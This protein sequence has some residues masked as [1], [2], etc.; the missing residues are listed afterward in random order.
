LLGEYSGL[1]KEVNYLVFASIFPSLVIGMFY[2]DISYFLSQVQGLSAT[3]TGLVIAVMGISMVLASIPM[4]IA[5]D[6]YGRKKFLI[7]GNILASLIIAVFVLTTNPLLLILAAVVEG[8]SEAAFNASSSALIAEKAGNEKRTVA[9]ALFGF[10]SGI[11]MGVGSFMVP[12]VIIFEIFG[13]TSQEGHALLYI[14]LALISLASTAIMLKITE[15]KSL[16]KTE[17]GLRHLLPNKS[18][19]VLIK[20]VFANAIIAFGAGLV[21]PLM[22]MWFGLRYG[23]TDAISVPII[24]ISN[25]V[26]GIATLAAPPL[27]R[28]IGL[29]RAIVVTQ[30]VSTIFMFATPI[31]PE[32][33]SASFVYTIRSFLMN[34]ASPLQN[35]MIM[36][37]VAEDERGTASG[38]SGALWRL[39]NAVSAIVGAWL[40]G[41]G[42]LA[43]P[44]F[45]AGLLYIISIALFWFYFRNTKMPEEIS[46]INTTNY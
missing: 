23:I 37:L 40:M 27:A 2:T 4:G 25:I 44:F 36:G 10:V 14:M 3:F 43:A 11:A 42:L 12:L 15:S 20:Y 32:Y 21:V 31:S 13:F 38:I 45:L 26:I 22:S 35:S 19:D 18:R 17:G 5:A 16:K 39:P 6:K 41:L 46:N 29:V 7:I 28:K 8:I 1:P 24:G 33:I 34:M 30:G 9:F